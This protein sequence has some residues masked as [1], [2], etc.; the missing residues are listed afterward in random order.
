MYLA[1]SHCATSARNRQYAYIVHTISNAKFS[2]VHLVTVVVVV[3]VAAKT[4]EKTSED[5][6]GNLSLRCR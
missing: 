4:A 2:S 3:V 6:M 1:D 5:Q